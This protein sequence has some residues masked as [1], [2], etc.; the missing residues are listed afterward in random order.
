MFYCFICRKF[1]G[2]EELTCN[3][4]EAFVLGTC[5]CEYQIQFATP[6]DCSVCA[7]WSV[8][9]RRTQ[10]VYQKTVGSKCRGMDDIKTNLKKYG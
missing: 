8:T 7:L 4:Q 9:E 1:F 6:S 2:C 5:P 3:G 10:C